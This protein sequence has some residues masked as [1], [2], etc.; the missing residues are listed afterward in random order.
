MFPS[1]YCCVHKKLKKRNAGNFFMHIKPQSTAPAQPAER[2]ESMYRRLFIVL[3]FLLIPGT[4]RAD[5]VVFKNGERL[6][7]T[8]IR[9]EQA[10]IIFKSELMGEV[11][12]DIAQVKELYTLKPV[13]VH[14]LDGTVLTS[15]SLRDSEGLLVIES[16]ESLAPRVLAP[17]DIAAINPPVKVSK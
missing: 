14:L 1:D 6:V 13:A 5:E 16:P 3:A 11:S 10:K 9:V 15:T 12:G 2:M 4:S 17:A 7:G 8:F